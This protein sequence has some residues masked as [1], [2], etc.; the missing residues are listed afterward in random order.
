MI[1]ITALQD[2]IRAMLKIEPDQDGW[3]TGAHEGKKLRLLPN[4][5][6]GLTLLFP[7]DY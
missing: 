4:E 3:R 6:G 2:A 1:D 5:V 7:D